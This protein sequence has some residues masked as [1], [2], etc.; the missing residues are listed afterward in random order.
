MGL[1]SGR[2]SV[3]RVQRHTFRTIGTVIAVVI[4]VC[5]TSRVAHAQSATLSQELT[6]MIN[7]YVGDW[8]SHD[9][10][11][12][13]A[14][15]TADADMIMGNGPIMDGR[16]A[17]QG[18]WQDYFA[19]QEPARRLTIEVEGIRRL[20][21][22]VALINVRTTTGGRTDQGVELAAR[23]F[24]GTW[25]VVREDSDWL[26]AAMRGLPTLQDRI[27]RGSRPGG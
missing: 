2:I 22:D 25:V 13:A 18:A 23:R 12:L 21:G 20:T 3:P 14:H 11:A 9:A 4:S 24:R 1:G 15:F 26:I 10:A 17:I 19:V 6:T 16:D 8:D 5:G 7:Q 27:L